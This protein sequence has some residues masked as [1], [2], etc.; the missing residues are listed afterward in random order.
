[1]FLCWPLL[2]LVLKFFFV[3]LQTTWTQTSDNILMAHIL[4]KPL[5]QG[6]LWRRNMIQDITFLGGPAAMHLPTGGQWVG[7][8]T[9]CTLSAVS[10]AAAL[11]PSQK[12]STCQPTAARRGMKPQPGTEKHHSSQHHCKFRAAISKIVRKKGQASM[13]IRSSET[14]RIKINSGT[15]IFIRDKS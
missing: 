7:P 13:V 5:T 3:S 9:P 8:Q 1:M 2:G 6:L 12:H 14:M 11:Q 4:Q 15:K 10:L